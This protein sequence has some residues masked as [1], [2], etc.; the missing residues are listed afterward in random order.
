MYH[1][2]FETGILNFD[3]SDVWKGFQGNYPPR[4]WTSRTNSKVNKE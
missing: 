2:T 1:K 4:S 3:G